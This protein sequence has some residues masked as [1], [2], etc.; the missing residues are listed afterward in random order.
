MYTAWGDWGSSVLIFIEA[1]TWDIY[2]SAGRCLDKGEHLGKLNKI[3]LQ[4]AFQV[5][6]LSG[7][8]GQ[9][10]HSSFQAKAQGVLMLIRKDVPFE[11]QSIVSDRYGG[12][13]IVSGKLYNTPVVLVK[14]L[15]PNM[16]DVS[17]FERWSHYHQYIFS[18][19]R[20]DFSCWLHPVLD[21]PSTNFSVV[22]GLACSIQAF[23]SNYAVC[24]IWRFLHLSKR[25]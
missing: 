17:F 7:W 12:Y 2:L 6:L 18:H 11:L 10:F 9:G 1:D 16:D 24:D 19:T 15:A 20:R 23:P 22:S 5:S 3:K 25:D 21:R 14:H 4:A 13:I 8:L